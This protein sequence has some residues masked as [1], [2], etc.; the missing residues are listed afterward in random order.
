MY[1]NQPPTS[2]TRN[3]LV[4]ILDN[5]VCWNGR[6]IERSQAHTRQSARPGKRNV[7]LCTN[8]I[9][10]YV[11][12]PSSLRKAITN[13]PALECSSQVQ[14]DVIKRHALTLVDR[15]RPGQCQWQLFKVESQVITQLTLRLHATCLRDTLAP[16]SSVKD[17]I[18][19]WTSWVNEVLNWTTGVPSA[20]NL[21]RQKFC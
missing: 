16:C 15:D 6:W 19:G 3:F 18:S 10:N 17:Q 21:H 8:S 7:G 2:R 5:R 11:S 9:I 14:F 13:L 12:Q 20:V 1:E 4:I